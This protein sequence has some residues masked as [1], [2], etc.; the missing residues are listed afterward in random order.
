MATQGA[1]AWT[2]TAGYDTFQKSSIYPPRAKE[3]KILGNTPHIPVEINACAL[4]PVDIQMM[5]LPYGDY[6][7]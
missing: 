6:Q 4:N 7:E 5:N 1:K 2:Y 3:I